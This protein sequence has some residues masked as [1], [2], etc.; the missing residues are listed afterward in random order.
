ME[1]RIYVSRVI[2]ALYMFPF[3]LPSSVYPSTA[4]LG[5]YGLQTVVA[6]YLN[7]SFDCDDNI[8]VKKVFFFAFY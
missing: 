5:K 1:E 7:R 3:H 6:L 8:E 4:L 2:A